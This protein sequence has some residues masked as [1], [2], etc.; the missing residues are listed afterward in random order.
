MWM[1]K[2]YPDYQ[3]LM[4]NT[5]LIM[6]ER[7]KMIDTMKRILKPDDLIFFQ[8]GYNTHDLE[9]SPEDFMHQ[10]VIQA[11]PDTPMIMMPQTVYFQTEK[12]KKQCS[13]IYNA[14]KKLL[15][16]SRDPVSQKLAESMFPDLKVV[17]YP[18]IVTSLIGKK[19]YSN[20]RAG[21]YLCRRKDSEQ[22][23]AEEDYVVFANVLSKLDSVDVSDTI[24]SASNKEIYADLGRYVDR[25]VERFAKYRLVVTDKY[26]GLIFSLIAGIPVI[27]LKTKDHKV[28]SG[29][30]WFSK[31]YPDRVFYA[32]NVNQL[33]EV[34]QEVLRNPSYSKL[35]DYFDKE[36]YQKLHIVI[37]NWMNE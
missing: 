3:I 27:V 21:V 22:F 37:N 13:S 31:I 1:Q 16:F 12:R 4:C 33:K 28:V 23:W 32:E 35:D 36:Y 6:D 24:I 20:A 11:F 10:K 2:T 29:Y 30:E 5:S 34:S 8:S 7:F 18:D 15:F 14:H 26:H 17:L 9:G 19:E 25:I